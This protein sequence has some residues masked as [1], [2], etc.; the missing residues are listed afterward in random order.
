MGVFWL[1]I[2][3][4]F[5]L[6]FMFVVINLLLNV[7]FGIIWLVLLEVGGFFGS[8]LGG[9]DWG[10]LIG[11]GCDSDVVGLVYWNEYVFDVKF[12]C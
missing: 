4:I 6:G 9:F 5:W 1:I 10:G 12:I 7:F 8:L 2:L 11:L 3:E